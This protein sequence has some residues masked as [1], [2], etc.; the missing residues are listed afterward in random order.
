MEGGFYIYAIAAADAAVTLDAAGI[1]E[2]DATVQTLPQGDIAAVVSRCAADR[3]EVT[4]ANALAHQR[5]MEAAMTRWPS[6]TAPWPCP[7]PSRTVTSGWP[8]PSGS[9]SARSTPARAS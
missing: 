6:A 2:N 8:E 1:G 3:Y 7:R 5:V 9:S 4:R